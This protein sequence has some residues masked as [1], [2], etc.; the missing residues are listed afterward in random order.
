MPEVE[1][2]LR[3]IAQSEIASRGG[4][5]RA[6]PPKHRCSS[7]EINYSPQTTIISKMLPHSRLGYGVVLLL[8]EVLDCGVACDGCCPPPPPPAMPL[9]FE[10]WFVGVLLE[11]VELLVG[12]LLFPGF[13]C[14]PG[15]PLRR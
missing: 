4:T 8:V 10:F 3:I 9:I 12:E 6:K 14:F 5:A 11:L 13:S 1:F 7:L 2:K 15:P